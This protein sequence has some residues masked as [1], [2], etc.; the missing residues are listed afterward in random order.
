VIPVIFLCHYFYLAYYFTSV[1]ELMSNSEILLLAAGF[2]AGLLLI[3]AISFFYFFRADRS[4]VRRM[5][6]LMNRPGEY[7]THLGPSKS[8]YHDPTLIQVEWYLESFTRVRPVRDV[9][10]YTPQFV[11]SL[12]KQHHFSAILSV[13]AA[14]LFLIGIGFCLESPFFQIPAAASITIFFSVLIGV[15][16]AFSYFLQSWSI[17]YLALL[18]II[19]NFLYKIDW[20]D[21]RNKAYGL[22]YQNSQERPAYNRDGLLAI[23]TPAKITADSI[24]MVS[25]LEKVEE[26]TGQ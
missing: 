24:N 23:C 10:H 22:N 9:K 15:A 14:F 21:P 16:G 13:F 3:L 8:D 26:E 1:K 11:D 18:V 20:I 4:I 7:I 2:L 5:M 25:I 19:L 6:P 17:P 12:F